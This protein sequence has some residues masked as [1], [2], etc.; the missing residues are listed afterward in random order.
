MH[1]ES[2]ID[3]T[4]PITR[5]GLDAYRVAYWY[6]WQAYQGRPD[7]RE[8]AEGAAREAVDCLKRSD[9]AATDPR[10]VH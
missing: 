7:R 5:R 1:I 4:R 3:A 10:L 6:A 9:A 2:D 8:R